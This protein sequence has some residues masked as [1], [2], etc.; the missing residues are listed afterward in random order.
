MF[1]SGNTTSGLPQHRAG[2]LTA[3]D[4]EDAAALA[5]LVFLRAQRHWRVG[6]ALREV[7]DLAR[8][9]IERELVAV[10]RVGHRLWTLH[11]VQAEIERV[12][13]EDV[14]HVVPADDHHLEAHFF[15]NGLEPGR[16]HLAGAADR[17][18]I[19]GNHERFA[20]MHA[21]AEIRHQVAERSGL[22]ALVERVEAFRHAIGGRRDLIGIDRVE[23]LRRILRVPE[24]QGAAA[25]RAAARATAPARSDATRLWQ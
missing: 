7:G 5:N 4:G 1:S 20:A 2:E 8:H 12:A 19:A 14:A 10:L 24:D 11:D 22:P 23:L 3:A 9:R 13:A 15:G 6:L 21:G 25:D 18:S 16:R 17:K